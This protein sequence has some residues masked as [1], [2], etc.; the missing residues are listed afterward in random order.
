MHRIA[1]IGNQMDTTKSKNNSNKCT[2]NMRVW[3]NGEEGMREGGDREVSNC[4]DLQHENKTP[5]F[6]SNERYEWPLHKTTWK[7]FQL[8]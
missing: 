5:S 8:P 2:I 3:G 4:M 6:R 1:H 7:G